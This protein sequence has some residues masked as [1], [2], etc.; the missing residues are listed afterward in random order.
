MFLGPGGRW[1]WIVNGETC[2]GAWALFGRKQGKGPEKRDRGQGVTVGAA[3]LGS[4]L[5]YI[6]VDGVKEYQFG[7]GYYEADE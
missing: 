2:G 7:K 1:A 6:G 3:L 5:D 4:E